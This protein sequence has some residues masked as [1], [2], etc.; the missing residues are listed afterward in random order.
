MADPSSP[1][2]A[3]REG[4]WFK[5]ICGA[6]FQHLPAIRSLALAYGLAGA[7]CIDVAADPAVVAAVRSAWAI[8]PTLGFTPPTW[9]PPWLM[10]SLNDG[11]DPHFRK[12]F[13]D[14][15]T[16]PPDCLR[17][18]EQVCPTQAIAAWPNGAGV[19]PGV[20]E[21]L[22]YGCGRCLP[23]CPHGRIIAHYRGLSPVL[24]GPL[25][26][27]MAPDA[28][29]IHTQIGR[30]R[31]FERLWRVIAPD[32]LGHLKLVAISCPGGPGHGDY[33]KTLYEIMAPDLA[34]ADC[35]LLWQTDGRPMSGDIGGGTTHAAIALAQET[36]ALNLPGFVQLAGGTNDHTWPRLQALGLLRAIAGVAYGGYGRSQLQPILDELDAIAHDRGQALNLEDVPPLLHRAVDRARAI[37]GLHHPTAAAPMP[38]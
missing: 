14:P 31:A 4:R 25:L 5:L 8:A 29:E 19:T 20:I 36:L 21:P 18:C 17:P 13:F 9:T 37:V 35:T 6:S 11:E 33:L 26:L 22:C 2:M 28:L 15:A 10:V 3:L 7:H 30:D 32:L 38:P 27:E 1:L 34:I 23:V 12:A 16:C 24:V